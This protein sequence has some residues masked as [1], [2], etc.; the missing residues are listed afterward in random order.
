MGVRRTGGFHKSNGWPDDGVFYARLVQEH[1]CE[2]YLCV[3]AWKKGDT[4]LSGSFEPRNDGRARIE[5]H[6]YLA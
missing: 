4:S 3:W 5:Q 6:R 1:E 2:M